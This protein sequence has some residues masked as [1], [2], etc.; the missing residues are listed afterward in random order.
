[1]DSQIEEKNL[2]HEGVNIKVG[3]VF[4]YLTMALSAVIAIF[5]PPYLLGRVGDTQYGLNNYASSIAGW[6]SLLCFGLNNTYIRFVTEADKKDRENGVAKMNGFYFIIFGIVLVLEVVGGLI[7]G[8]V[9]RFAPI[10]AQYTAAEKD[11]IFFIL[12]LTVTTSG[13][14]FF[15]GLY[16]LFAYYNSRLIFGQA[17]A[18]IS[19]LIVA[20]GTTLAVYF[21]GN[22]VWYSACGL[23]AQSFVDVT[24]VIYCYKTLKMKIIFPA[25]KEFSKMF[26]DVFVFSFYVFMVA[27]VDLINTNIGKTVLGNHT[28]ASLVTIFSLGYDFYSYEVT[29]SSAFD[30]NIAPKATR[31]A[32]EGKTDE[33]NALFLKFST[34]QAL[35]LCLVVGGYLSCG[36]DFIIAWVG[37]ER[38][39]A[40]YIG[41]IFLVLWAFPLSETT[42]ITIQRALNKHQFLSVVNLAA[43]VV[44]IGVTVLCVIYLPDDYKI[45]GATAGTIFSVV[46]GM[47]VI[48]NI[49]YKKELKL[50]IGHFLFSFGMI[51]AIT[52]VSVVACWLLFRFGWDVTSYNKWLI[53]V[54]KGL[55]FCIFYGLLAVLFFRKT[56]LEKID[57]RKKAK[58]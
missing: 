58:N 40:F 3:I 45:Y 47:D 41:I 46:I 21:G 37:P 36:K 30:A 52:A 6:F 27:I 35:V 42:G 49:F 51:A 34:L 14:G 7:V 39:Q 56:I 10:L 50:P 48:S 17:L 18:L 44:G 15:L 20:G 31:L 16:P 11:I 53:V 29:M 1:M 22:I 43:T 32:I 5:L 57:E 24:A 23:I 28:N 9:I 4:S 13:I 8:L 55:V 54:I 12:M 2:K 38:I 25:K 33:L 19:K 26:H